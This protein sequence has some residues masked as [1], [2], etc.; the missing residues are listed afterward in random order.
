[1]PLESHEP[2]RDG[3][4][5]WQA[6]CVSDSGLDGPGWASERYRTGAAITDCVITRGAPSAS[7]P[8][9]APIERTA[10]SSAAGAPDGAYSSLE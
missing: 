10:T 2:F 4:G 5:R 6:K 8:A 9:R 3:P 1:M 7:G